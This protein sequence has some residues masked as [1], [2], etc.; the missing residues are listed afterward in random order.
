MFGSV[1][2]SMETRPDVLLVDDEEVVRDGA[3]RILEAHG[4]QVAVA[5]DARSA[6]T[7]PALQRCRAVLCDLIL[8]DGSGTDLLRAIHRLRPGL[9]VVLITGYATLDQEEQ[10]RRAGATGFLTKPFDD[11]ELLAC[12]HRTLPA[13]ETVFGG[14]QP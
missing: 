8:P 5:A 12:L 7:H 2:Q 10:A 6:L 4:L 11:S 9:P 1:R 3:R 14:R 13:R